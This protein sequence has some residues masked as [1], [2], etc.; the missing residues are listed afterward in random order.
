M[1]ST[2]ARQNVQ[3]RSTIFF[4]FIYGSVQPS[5]MMNDEL[6]WNIFETDFFFA[7]A[8]VDHRFDRRHAG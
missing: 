2:F 8:L 6:K 4:G 3:C 1:A 7:H 5:V